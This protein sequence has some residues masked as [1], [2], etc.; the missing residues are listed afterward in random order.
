MNK[1]QFIREV[2]DKNQL[3]NDDTFVWCGVKETKVKHNI[4][5]KVSFEIYNMLK[6][7]PQH[8]LWDKLYIS[9]CNYIDDLDLY[10]VTTNQDK[11]IINEEYRLEEI[12]NDSCITECENRLN[13][14]SVL[15]PIILYGYED[16]DNELFYNSYDDC[17]CFGDAIVEFDVIEKN[18][19]NIKE[20]IVKIRE[21]SGIVFLQA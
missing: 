2:I 21:I 10:T 13:D 12:C 19:K 8:K 9:F 3:N 15:V 20:S 11:I 17:Y 14:G 4:K 16:Y 6:N 1:E 5:E 18:E 7:N